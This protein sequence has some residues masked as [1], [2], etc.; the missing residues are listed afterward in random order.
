MSNLCLLRS[1]ALSK[2]TMS[3]VNGAPVR[4]IATT[5]WEDIESLLPANAGGFSAKQ[6]F[7]NTAGCVAYT[8]DDLILMP[9][10]A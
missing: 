6:V 8:Y 2:S 7:E 10:T 5:K 9:G 1:F 4:D 3:A